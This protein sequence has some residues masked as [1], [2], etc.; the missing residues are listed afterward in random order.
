MRV[1]NYIHAVR[2]TPAR[3]LRSQRLERHVVFTAACCET[4]T[5]QTQYNTPA[6]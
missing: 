1:N 5:Q 3:H 4:T 6:S 2:K